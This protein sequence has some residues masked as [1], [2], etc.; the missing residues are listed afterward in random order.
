MKRILA[1]LLFVA[2][3]ALLLPWAARAQP[4]PSASKRPNVLFLAVDDLRPSFGVYGGPIKSP[5]LD[6]L[7]AGGT[8]FVRAYCQ[9]AVYSPS[10][11]SLLTGQRPDTTRVYDLQTHFRTTLPDVVTLPQFFKQNGYHAQGMGKI[12]H[13]GL[14]DKASWSVPHA[15]PSRPTYGPST[16]ADV[17]RRNDQ[18]RTAGRDVSGKKRL[19]GPAWEAAEGEDTHFTDGALADLAIA[20]LGELNNR[21]AGDQR[22]FFLAVGFTRPHL[23]FVAPKKYWDLYQDRDIALPANYRSAP[24]NV[25]DVALHDSGELRAYHGIPKTG[26]VTDEQ[27]RLLLHGYYAAASYMDAQVGRV[28]DALD[29]LGMRENTVVVLWGD[30]GWSLG[31][32]GLWCKHTNFENSTRA[33]LILSVPGQKRPGAKT[34]QLAEFVDIY[35]TLAHAAGLALPAGLAGKSLLP[36]ANDP[37]VV[38]KTAAFSQYPRGGGVMG[39][40]LR[41][42]RW[43]Y[44]E[45]GDRGRELYDHQT[46]PGENTNVAAQPEN[47][48]LVEQLSRQLR[49]ALPGAAKQA[50]R[51]AQKTE[52]K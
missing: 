20:T 25:P 41:T 14:D 2:L 4:T 15:F 48:A 3:V 1:P 16:E 18:A 51:L 31:E 26:P 8:T 47:K 23:P 9:Q 17:K 5:N 13:N 11:T 33:P 10:R 45:W 22:P 32:H 28:L 38:V 34:S 40:S 52:K 19:R 27:A 46:D 24:K 12:Y 49:A 50:E 36:L 42:D 7:A 44:T 29:R 6:R 39:Y 30:H 37:D 35:P 21:P 43:R